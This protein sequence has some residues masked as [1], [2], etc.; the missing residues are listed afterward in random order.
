MSS[1]NKTELPP[2]LDLSGWRKLP[3]VFMVI[4]AILSIIGLI[5]SPREF[6]YSWLLSFLFFLTLSLGA[7]FFAIIHHLTDAGWS[8]AT[9][10]I[11]EHIG[12]LLFPWLAILFIPV[13]LLASKIYPWMTLSPIHDRAISAKGVLFTLRGFCVASAIFFG[14]WW[15][16]TARINYWSLRQDVTGD[17]LCTRKMRFHSGWGILAFAATVTVAPIVWM[18]SLE[19]QWSST[20][21]GLYM[22]ASCGWI[23]LA[24]IYILTAVLQRQRILTPV[25]HDNQFYF[26]GVLFF[27]FTLLQAYFEFAQYFVVWNGNVPEETY[28]YLIRENGSWWWVS[29]VLIFGHF[30][31]PFVLLLPA[32][33]K[34]N[35][36]IMIPICAWAWLMNFADLAFNVLPVLHPHGYPFKW[37]WLHFGTFAFMA[38][39]LSHVFLKKFRSHPPYPQRDPRVLEAMGIGHEPDEMP[40]T[41]PAEGGAQ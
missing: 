34:M 24:T 14:I 25:L 10:R 37:I 35:F 39:L 8:V 28:F 26:L 38:G 3:V 40:D 13:I 1:Q 23:A 41:L 6:S 7:L 11:C 17:A 9:R 29:M 31:L 12:S 16:L 33:V 4:G 5:A 27:A 36:K 20:M 19:Y 22:F 15:A 21:Y 2:P 18:N 32:H 30:F